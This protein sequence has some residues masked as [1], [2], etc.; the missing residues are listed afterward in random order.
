MR[1]GRIFPGH[2]DQPSHARR[3]DEEPRG[4]GVEI[5]A[6][7]GNSLLGAEICGK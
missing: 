7:E 1:D 5:G 2:E 3:E 4:K 6:G